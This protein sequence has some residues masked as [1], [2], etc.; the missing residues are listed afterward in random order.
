MSIDRWDPFRDAMSLRDAFNRLFDET[1]MRPGS[2]WLSGF[3]DRPAMDV[4]QNDEAVTIEAHLPGIKREELEITISGSLLTIKGE[5]HAKQELKEEH[6]LRREVHYGTFMRQIM[7]P[8]HADPE[9]ATAS[10][11]DGVLK[12]VFPKQAAPQPRKIDLQPE[13]ESVTA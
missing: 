4:Y 2:E 3:R 10:F 1:L 8:E 6:Y 9:Q 5:R 13:S 12:L 7:L 11:S